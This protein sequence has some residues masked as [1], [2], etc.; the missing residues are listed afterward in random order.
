MPKK[1]RWLV[2]NADIS[3]VL[4]KS[5][6][7]THATAGDEILRSGE[8]GRIAGFTVYE[9][10]EVA[11]DSN[12]WHVLAGHPSA[13]TFAK[14]FVETEIEPTLPATSARPTKD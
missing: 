1:D 13:I 2:V 12:G 4:I 9:N 8:I 10:E 14:A 11:G 7:F 5:D 6:D 3:G